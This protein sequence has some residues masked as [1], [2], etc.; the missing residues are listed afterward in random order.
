MG[1]FRLTTVSGPDAPQRGRIGGPDC[2]F[3]AL[4]GGWVI[5][6]AVKEKPSSEGGSLKGELIA[7]G[8]G[9]NPH[10]VEVCKLK[11]KRTATTIPTPIP[12]CP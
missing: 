2:A 7:L 12:D 1:F 4:T 3:S 6:A 8:V 9:T 10:R 11:L 5:Q